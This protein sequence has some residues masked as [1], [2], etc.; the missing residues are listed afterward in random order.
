PRRGRNLQAGDWPVAG[1]VESEVG[2]GLAERRTVGGRTLPDAAAPQRA[3][4][5]RMDVQVGCSISVQRTGSRAGRRSRTAA[6]NA[7]YAVLGAILQ[8]NSVYRDAA[9]HITGNDFQD[10]RLGAVFDGLG[11][12]INRGETV[13]AVTV[14]LYFPDW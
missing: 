1:L 10:P 3:E 7:E 2:A 14:E 5:R 11:Q 12:V 13:D 9:Q 8:S 4:E 6:M